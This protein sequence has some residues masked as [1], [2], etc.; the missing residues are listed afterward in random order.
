ML[1]R[2]RKWP[3]SNVGWGELTRNNVVSTTWAVKAVTLE[4]GT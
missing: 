2:V 1:C 4:D 3:V